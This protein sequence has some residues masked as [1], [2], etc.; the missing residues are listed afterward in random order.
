MRKI[1]GAMVAISMAACGG[2]TTSSSPDARVNNSDANLTPDA[3]P[4]ADAAPETLGT[5]HVTWT[6]QDWN[7]QTGLPIAAACPSGADTVIVYSLP[8]GQTDPANAYTDLFTCAD[9]AGT[10]LGLPPGNY[11]VWTEVVDHANTVLYAQSGSVQATVVANQNVN[12][13]FTFQVNRGYVHASWSLISA[14]NQAITCAQRPSIAGVAFD[15]TGTGASL[16]GDIFTCSDLQGTTY[17]LPLDT[18]TLSVQAIDNGNPPNGIGA[19]ATVPNV[20]VTFGNEL[21]EAGAVVLDV[22]AP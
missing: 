18:Y 22:D 5:I 9:G 16:V 12:T 11:T 3:A 7:D 14:Q 1:F 8:A 17:P 20:K 4:P 2:G 10:T 15:Q 21:T 13:A 6:L 19:A